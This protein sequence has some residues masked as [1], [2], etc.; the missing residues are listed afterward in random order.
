LDGTPAV[1][2]RLDK[3]E[4]H[5]DPGGPRAGSRGDQLRK[6][7]RGFDATKAAGVRQA[8]KRNH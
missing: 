8:M 6:V 2:C 7:R 5:R 3:F 1:L 4:R